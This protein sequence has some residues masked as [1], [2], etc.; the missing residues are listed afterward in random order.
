M[1]NKKTQRDYY[2]ELLTNYNLSQEHIDFINSRLQALDKK[3]SR[4][5]PTPTQLENI[6]LSNKKKKW[7]AKYPNGKTT[8]QIPN[9]F[10]KTSQKIKKKKKKLIDSEKV[11]FK[12][13][14][15]VKIF[16]VTNQG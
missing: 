11:S 1:S 14:K 3:S 13:E 12:L 4:T 15:K 6:N 2:N 5:A 16:T 10:G 9:H 8:K 7:L